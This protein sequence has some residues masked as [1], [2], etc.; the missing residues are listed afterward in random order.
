M[1]DFFKNFFI[2]L[3]DFVLKLISFLLGLGVKLVLLIFNALPIP[4]ALKDFVMIWPS[5]TWF[6]P[7]MRELGVTDGIKL[8]VA[9]YILGWTI[10]AVRMALAFARPGM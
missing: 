4:Q 3:W 9:G 10:K 8:I 2:Y 1:I 6:F 7:L 5:D